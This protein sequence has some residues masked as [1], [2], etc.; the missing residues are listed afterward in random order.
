MY[1]KELDFAEL[2]SGHAKLARE[3][4]SSGQESAAI[5]WKYG[6]GMNICEPS[7]FGQLVKNPCVCSVASFRLSVSLVCPHPRTFCA[8]ILRSRRNACIWMG[9]LCS[10]WV[11]IAKGSTKRSFANPEGWESYPSVANG[12]YMAARP[13]LL[14]QVCLSGDNIRAKI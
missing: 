6:R 1:V 12:N 13:A 10:S 8:S 9:V 2:F 5:D 7:G 11:S 4:H 14:V 3:F